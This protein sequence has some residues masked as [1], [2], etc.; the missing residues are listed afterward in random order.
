MADTGQSK[1]GLQQD[2]DWLARTR[3]ELRLQMRLARSETRSELN[4][5]EQTWQ[6]V[7][8]EIRRVGDYS[9]VPASELAN[10]ARNLLE[11]LKGGYERVKRELEEARANSVLGPSN[12]DASTQRAMAEAEEAATRAP[13]VR[14][15]EQLARQVGAGADARAV[16]APPITREGVTVIPVA[17]VGGG[18]GVGAGP[19]GRDGES[20]EIGGV[21]GGGGF[22]SMPIGFIEIDRDGARFQRL[23]S[24]VDS[25]LGVAG[26][27]FR[28]AGRGLA[29]LKKRKG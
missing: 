17:R 12:M 15:I 16:F 2:L 19:V 26:F 9:K 8:D 1:D 21:G 13:F 20:G 28:A 11:E 25:W 22:F 14:V 18:F 24:P 3:D 23:E 29:L 10:S 4:R 5:L 6:R 7:Q 27:V